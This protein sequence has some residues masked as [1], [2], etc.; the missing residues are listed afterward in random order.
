MSDPQPRMPLRPTPSHSSH[1]LNYRHYLKYTRL[2]TT[3]RLE[4]GWSGP[5]SGSCGGTANR[6]PCLPVQGV[7]VLEVEAFAI[8]V[9]PLTADEYALI[10]W[11]T[12]R[13]WNGGS[14]RCYSMLKTC[15]RG[16]REFE[17]YLAPVKSPYSGTGTGYS[18]H[19]WY[20]GGYVVFLSCS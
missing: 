3:T 9:E 7:G 4:S 17:E 1:D 20:I 6:E 8:Q 19:H 5:I 14:S 2:T 10:V 15:Q 12:R 18:I 13:R 11:C 16:V